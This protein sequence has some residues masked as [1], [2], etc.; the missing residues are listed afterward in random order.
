MSGKCVVCGRPPGP[1]GKTYPLTDKERHTMRVLLQSD[2][3]PTYCRSCDTLMH[4][5]EAAA[6]FFKGIWIT[7]LRAA[8]VPLPVAEAHAQKAYEFYLKKAVRRTAPS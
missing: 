6:E 5:P 1:N 4:N 8:G 2:E 3:D 7:K